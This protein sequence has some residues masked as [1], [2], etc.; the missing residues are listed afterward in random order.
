MDYSSA[1]K[2]E[3]SGR[4]CQLI[5]IRSNSILLLNDFADAYCIEALQE[6]GLNSKCELVVTL[7]REQLFNI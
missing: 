6:K 7:K 1:E 2:V 3:D 4:L 5:V